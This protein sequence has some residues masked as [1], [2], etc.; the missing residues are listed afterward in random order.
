M[1]SNAS[2]TAAAWV[3]EVVHRLMPKQYDF[4]FDDEHWELLY[5]GAF[6]AGKSRA[7]CC[8]A[9]R[10]AQYPGARVGLTRKT[11]SDLKASTLITL[12][13]ADGELPPV[14][15]P[16]SYVYKR[17][18][19]R[20]LLKNGGEIVCFGCD[21]PAKVGS[22]PLSDVL[23]DEGIELAK[24]EYDMLLGRR[25]GKYTRPDGTENTRSIA[26]AT[27]PGSPTH[28]LHDRFF[29]NPHPK[30]LLI[31]THTSENYHL[32]GDYVESLDELTGSARQRYFLGEW[33]A[34]EG[35]IYWMFNT[36]VHITRK[37]EEYDYYVAGV[38][39][40]FQNPNIIR[41]H[42][43]K[44]GWLGSHV[45]HEFYRS[46]VVSP[47]FVK[48]CQEI[49]NR[50]APITF[51]IDGSAADLIQ[52]I[53]E[54]GL[55]ARRQPVTDVLQGIRYVQA[56]LTYSDKQ[57]PDLTMDPSCKAGNREYAAYRWKEGG[58]KEEPIKELDHALDADRYAVTYIRRG[59]GEPAR[60]T[61]LGTR[62]PRPIEQPEQDVPEPEDGK[63]DPMDPKYWPT[64]G[65][66][67][68]R[69]GA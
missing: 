1:I 49:A 58:A 14:L 45:V 13:E 56:A 21:N 69:T 39:Q 6:G 3:E 8:R 63:F 44:H 7:L 65:G 50:Y 47:E 54:V 68:G 33:V 34:Y 25:R 24:D 40:G 57:A 62:K 11:L 19:S 28:F 64:R 46:N 2:D 51:I 5:S 29:D 12:L 37:D 42:G 20:I 32:P 60:L 59:L 10:L 67:F 48:V 22:R 53:L 27:N 30:R 35:A 15:P 66:S 17:A 55:H 4:V 41:V 26:I 9:L 31:T 16:G 43:C 61:T 36:S 38:D 52:Q 23:I 18:E